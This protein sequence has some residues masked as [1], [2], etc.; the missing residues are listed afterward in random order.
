LR[1]TGSSKS[2]PR[3]P[4]FPFKSLRIQ[5]VP[6][7]SVHLP[8]FLRS[9]RTIRLASFAFPLSRRSPFHRYAADG[10]PRC[11][12]TDTN[13]YL[14]Q[15]RITCYYTFPYTNNVLIGAHTLRAPPRMGRSSLP[16]PISSFQPAPLQVQRISDV[17]ASRGNRFIDRSVNRLPVDPANRNALMSNALIFHLI[18]FLPE[19]RLL[20]ENQ[21]KYP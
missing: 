12:P 5:S 9:F 2:P 10:N 21:S 7:P 8:R 3:L 15:R 1:S 11:P 4:P 20:C 14:C 13:G 19:H 17:P 16:L 18:E 6:S